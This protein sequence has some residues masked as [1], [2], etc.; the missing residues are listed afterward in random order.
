MTDSDSAGPLTG[1]RV[2]DLA[3]ERAEMCGRFLA[4]LGAEVIKIE[5]PGGAAARRLP[6]FEAGREGD[7][8]GSL[9][10]AAVGLGKHGVVLDIEDARDREKLRGL[11]RGADVFVESFDPGEMEKLGLGYDTIRELNPQLVYVSITPYGQSGPEAHSPATELTIEAAGGL[12]SLQGDGDRPPV[13]VGYP[14]AAFHAGG[15]AAADTIIALNE[16]ARSGLGQHLDVS[17]QTVMIWTLM[18]ATGYPPNHGDDI[19]AASDLRSGPPVQPIPGVPPRSLWQCR[20]GDVTFGPSHMGTGARTFQAMMNWLTE[21]GVCPPELEGINWGDWGNEVLE[22]RMKAET[23]TSAL[24]AMDAFLKTKGKHELMARAVTHDFLLAPIMSVGDLESD[25]QLVDRKFFE[26]IGGRRHP[27]AWARLT[28]TP[29]ALRKPAPKLGEDQALVETT[30]L[31]AAP[32]VDHSVVRKRAFEGLKIADFAW[33]GVGPIISKAFADHGATVVHVESATRPDA[34]R[35]APPFKNATPGLNNSQFQANFNSSKLGLGL[36]IA[37]P[38]GYE[39]ARRLI[40]W[41]DV[42]TESFTPGTMKKLGLDYATI[43]EGRADLVM[44][45]TCLRGQTGPQRSYGGFGGQGAALAGFHGVTGWPDRPPKGPWGAFTDF[46][47]PRFGVAVVG[48]AVL[49]RTRTGQGQHIDLSQ[50]EASIH[51]VEPLVL[52]YTVNGRVAKAAGHESNRACPHGIYAVRGTERY[53]AIACENPDQ[54]RALCAIAPLGRFADARLDDLRSRLECD[55]EIDATLSRWC[56][57]VDGWELAARLKSAGV[58]ASM[59][60]RPS[61]LY[62]DPQVTH[63]GFFV[64][65][66]HAVMGPTPYDGL[67]TVH[68]ETPGQLGPGPALGQHSNMILREFLGYSDHAV[69]AMRATGV[70]E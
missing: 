19:Q 30:H 36:K 69:E 21:E 70:V 38:D 8:E 67:S 51:F 10:W 47:A 58:P 15:Q 11:L 49:H 16:R 29:V 65:C 5:P 2:I 22:G 6:P 64:T 42:V 43:S 23:V 31:P 1:F 17:M 44:L 61:D 32:P 63:R 50:V 7:I 26:E 4:D 59:V 41:A 14:Q 66:D 35:M 34:L 53:I 20:D 3:T 39:V 13:P 62:K 54:W 52:D 18:N 57:D 37:T 28:R 40:D 68:S 12:V 25:A 55:A 27:G 56:A 46:V 9:Y 24:A 33:V 60:Q 48:A 45:S